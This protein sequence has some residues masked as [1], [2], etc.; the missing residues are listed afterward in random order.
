[1][2]KLSRNEAL[3]VE[4]LQ[5]EEAL[6]YQNLQQLTSLPASSV[7]SAVNSLEEKKVIE[8]LQSKKW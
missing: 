2:F 7:Y 8:R 6:S 5:K 1:M 3:I 4:A